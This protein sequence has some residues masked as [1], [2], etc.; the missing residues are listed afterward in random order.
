MFVAVISHFICHFSWTKIQ[1]LDDKGSALVTNASPHKLRAL[2]PSLPPGFGAIGSIGAIGSLQSV[3][4]QIRSTHHLVVFDGFW[5]WKCLEK[6]SKQDSRC[7]LKCFFFGVTFGHS[8]I[9]PQ[10]LTVLII[11]KDV[12]KG[13][14]IRHI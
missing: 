6:A 9:Y 13:R 1:L 2:L 3:T 8:S 12:C 14:H 7:L 5:V 4:I 10:V 11:L